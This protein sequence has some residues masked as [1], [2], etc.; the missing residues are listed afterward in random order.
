MKSI[1]TALA[2][3][4][5]L[6]DARLGDGMYDYNNPSN[7]YPSVNGFAIGGDGL[8]GLTGQLVPDWAYF[9]SQTYTF[10]TDATTQLTQRHLLKAG[11]EYNYYNTASEDRPYPTIMNLGQGIYTDV[12]RFYPTSGAVYLQDKMEYQ[13]IIVNLNSFLLRETLKAI[14][15]ILR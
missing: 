11:V 2:I 5:N 13:D 7:Q 15:K 8:A 4:P 14:D 6:Y 1:H 10:K 9:E 3:D 12:Y